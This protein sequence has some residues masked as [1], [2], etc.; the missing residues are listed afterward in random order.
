MKQTKAPIT[1]KTLAAEDIYHLAEQFTHQHPRPKTTRG[2]KPLYP[3]ALILTLALLQVAQ[4]ASYRQ[5]LFGLAPQLLPTHALPALGTWLYRLQTL[6]EARW[7]ALLTWLAEQGIALEQ[8]AKPSEKPL[9]LVDGTG[10]GFDTPY[11][12]Q[13]RRGAAIRQMRSHGKGVVLGYWR[14]GAV[15]LVGASLGDA[16]A[17]EAHL[18]A[19]WL[20]RYGAAGGTGLPVPCGEALWVGDKLYG[21]QA[22]LL[23]RVEAVGWLPVVRVAPSLYQ[24]VRAPSRLRAWGRLGEYGW[25]LKER[26]RIEQVFG[27]VKGAYGSYMGCRRVAYVRV[28]V[29]GQLVLWNMVQY[30]RVRG[31]G[32]FL[33][34]V[35]CGGCVMVVWWVEEEFSNTL[36]GRQRVFEIGEI[37]HPLL[38]VPPAWRGNLQEGVLQCLRFGEVWFDDWY[39]I[40]VFAFVPTPRDRSIRN[41]SRQRR[42]WSIRLLRLGAGTPLPA[43]CP[44]SGRVPAAR[45]R[46]LRLESAL[47]A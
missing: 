30:L 17:N 37:S 11:Y 13:Y 14:G 3:E 34:C 39:K 8:P 28:R 40:W 6:P 27:S 15:W 36:R 42:G 7:H 43:C 1:L 25:A 29:W 20:D 9:V 12:A 2:R 5:L 38:Q 19:E 21:R 45:S 4:Q 24:S 18:M 23:E 32:I 33:L 44:P 47:C 10:W 35:G 16:Y 26:Y 41:Q 31:G 46:C 22:R